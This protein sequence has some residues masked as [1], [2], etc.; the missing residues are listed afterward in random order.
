M[1][2]ELRAGNRVLTLGKRPLLMGVVN[3]SPDSFSDGGQ[4]STLD[5]QLALARSLVAAGAEILDVGGESGVTNSGCFFSSAS[6]RRN[7]PSYSASLIS[8]SSRT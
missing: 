2:V 3:A 4:W 7:K 6:R 1:T 5:E 8:G